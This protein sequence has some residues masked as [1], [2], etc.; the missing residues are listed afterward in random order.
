MSEIIGYIISYVIAYLLALAIS[1]LV[2]W[3][4]FRKTEKHVHD[5][6]RELRE[7]R[8]ALEKSH[9]ESRAQ[10]DEFDES[11]DEISEDIDEISEDI[12]EKDESSDEISESAD[13]M[14]ES[15][16]EMHQPINEIHEP[17]DEKDEYLEGLIEFTRIMRDYSDYKTK[18]IEARE[19]FCESQFWDEKNIH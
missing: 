1:L 6:I 3:L 17:S 9:N 18:R 13:E 14:S 7:N 19:N 12:D 5:S 2:V 11:S 8:A 15:I 10:V 4:I 16:G